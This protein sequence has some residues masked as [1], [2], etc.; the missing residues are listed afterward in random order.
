MSAY[1]SNME[2][3]EAN[4]HFLPILRDRGNN[5]EPVADTCDPVRL[6]VGD[7]VMHRYFGVC[8]VYG[9]D[10]T[11]QASESW[12]EAHDIRRL[13]HGVNQPFYHVLCHDG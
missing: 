3:L 1:R 8:V 5:G 2:V 10:V 11:C 12:I 9:W 13:I 4:G 7:V 6:C